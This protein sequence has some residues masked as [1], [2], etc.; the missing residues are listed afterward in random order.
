MKI[1]TGKHGR[2]SFPAMP[3]RSSSSQKWLIVGLISLFVLSAL[4][5]DLWP[6]KNIYFH[7]SLKVNNLLT[8]ELKLN[9]AMRYAAGRGLNSGD[10]LLYTALIKLV[11]QIIPYRLLCLRLVSLISSVVGLIFIY[12]LSARLFNRSAAILVLFLLVTSPVYLESMRSIGWVSLTNS[13]VIIFCYYLFRVLNEA[14]AR[15]FFSAGLLALIYYML[16]SLYALGRM[17][18][19]PALVLFA[20]HIKRCWKATLV[21][22]LI[23]LLLIMI[24]DLLIGDLK[25]D[26]RNFIFVSGEWIGDRT[27]ESWKGNIPTDWIKD[28]LENALKYFIQYD[29]TYFQVPL[30]RLGEAYDDVDKSRLFNIFYTPFFF[31]GL[32]ICL[33]KRRTSDIFLLIW[34][35]TFF[36]IPLFSSGVPLRRFFLILNPAYLLISIGLLAF[37]S[38]VSRFARE[39]KFK[40]IIICFPILLAAT[41]GYDLY[42]FFFKVAKPNCRYSR[43]QLKS[44]AEFIGNNSRKVSSITINVRDIDRIAEGLLWGNPYLDQP[45]IDLSETRK[46]TQLGDCFNVAKHIDLARKEG[47]GILFLYPLPNLK[48]EFDD[49]QE[50]L[51][52]SI[53]SNFSRLPPDCRSFHLPGSNFYALLVESQGFYLP[54]AANR[55]YRY[56]QPEFARNVY[57]SSEYSWSTMNLRLVDGLPETFWRISNTEAAEP[58]WIIIDLGGEKGREISGLRALPKKGRPTEFFRNAELFGSRN[59]KDWESVA[60]IV[61]KELPPDDQWCEWNFKNEKKFRYYKLMIYDGHSGRKQ[62]FLSMAELRLEE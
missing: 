59:G 8:M 44:V 41:G 53:K 52:S 50:E 43:E 5:A 20:V 48:T 15:A 11:Y 38:T 13:L 28:N 46:F 45:Y 56:G 6:S 12:R 55:M 26:F 36:L 35:F 33:W 16:F 18:I 58:A 49:S 19:I 22:S 17:A 31:L 62:R 57:V 27:A 40:A 14:K 42:E 24:P 61:Q 25:F 21:F 32:G 1:L 39:K 30:T 7:I 29:R 4:L 60:S 51:Y 47:T 2:S 10:S 34:F 37:I 3:I 23:L 9:P 54:A